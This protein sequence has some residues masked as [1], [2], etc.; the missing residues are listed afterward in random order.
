[1]CEWVQGAVRTA[2]PENNCKVSAKWG[3]KRKALHV[4]KIR[5]PLLPSAPH[6]L[7]RYHPLRARVLSA[8]GQ[9]DM[10]V[11]VC[12]NCW[13]EGGAALS[14]SSVAPMPASKNNCHQHPLGLQATTNSQCFNFRLA[15]LMLALLPATAL[16]FTMRVVMLRS[17]L[18]GWG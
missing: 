16:H 4:H 1:M 12:V 5:F 7:L 3:V 9:S 2:Q 6:Y 18:S 10:L 15:S 8:Q 11:L 17:G 13:R 14:C